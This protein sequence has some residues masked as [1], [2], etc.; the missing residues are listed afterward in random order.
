MA[1]KNRQRLYALGVRRI[2]TQNETCITSI[3]STVVAMQIAEI[4]KAQKD[5]DEQLSRLFLVILS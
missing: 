2:K 1:G 3:I 5:Q 4:I